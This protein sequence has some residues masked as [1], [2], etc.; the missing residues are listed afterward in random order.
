MSNLFKRLLICMAAGILVTCW[1]MPA[2]ALFIYSPKS[3]SDTSFSSSGTTLD[4]T[5]DQSG[6]PDQFKFTS[7]QTDYKT[8]IESNP[9]HAALNQSNAWGGSSSF[10]GYID[11]DLNEVLSVSSFALWGQSGLIGRFSINSFALFGS[12]DLSFGDD[13]KLGEFNGSLSLTGPIEVQ[14]FG[15]DA[16]EAR[17]IRLLVNSNFTGDPNSFLNIGE[18]A[19]GGTPAS[20]PIP[21]PATILLLGTG[22]AGLVGFGRRRFIAN[23]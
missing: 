11:F 20:A 19:F 8:Y 12:I 5:I 15:F 18:V 16:K 23:R 21:E 13:E 9:T 14:P 3:I 2:L 17:Y 7:G 4:R 6:L 22:L 1:S 10:P